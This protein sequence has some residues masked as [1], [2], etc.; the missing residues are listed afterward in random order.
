MEFCPEA[1]YSFT[2]N[3]L[4]FHQIES[5]SNKDMIKTKTEIFSSHKAIHGSEMNSLRMKYVDFN[6]IS[7]DVSYF[8]SLSREK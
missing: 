6:I 7:E 8:N 5:E 3:V 1:T 4:F 2:I